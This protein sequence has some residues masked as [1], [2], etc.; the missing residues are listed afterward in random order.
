MSINLKFRIPV[1][2]YKNSKYNKIRRG[3]L[4]LIASLIQQYLFDD[5]EINDD[6]YVNI[7]LGIE[8]SCYNHALEIAENDIIVPSFTNYVFE[9]LYRSNIIRITKN[10]DIDSEVND[11]YLINAILD[12]KIDISRISYLK[13]EELSPKINN[14]LIEKLHEKLNKKVTIKITNRYKC[15]K[16]KGNECKLEEVQLRSLDEGASESITCINCNYHWII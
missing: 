16:C 7:I 6:Q 15:K 5:D 1:E 8:Q 2:I 12:N 9:D 10:M 4:L 11:D 13:N 14:E 3:Y